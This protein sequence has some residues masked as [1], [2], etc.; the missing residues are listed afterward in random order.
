MRCSIDL[1]EFLTSTVIVSSYRWGLFAFPSC[2][3]VAR[4]R[5]IALCWC[6]CLTLGAGF[7]DGSTIAWASTTNIES[8]LVAEWHTDGVLG[9]NQAH[10][11]VACRTRL[12]C[13]VVTLTLP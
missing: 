13:R 12:V 3:R 5:W 8:H 11:C 10:A 6:A 1:P 7:V 4:W 9:T 2:K